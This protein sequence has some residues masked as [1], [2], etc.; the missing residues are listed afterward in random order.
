VG[1]R[2]L[3]MLIGDK[4]MSVIYSYSLLHDQRGSGQLDCFV[5]AKYIMLVV[6]IC[7]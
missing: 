5:K 7:H 2:A 1:V 3:D 6:I 4:S